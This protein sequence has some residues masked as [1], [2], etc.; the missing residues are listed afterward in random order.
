M[1][2]GVLSKEEYPY[3]KDPSGSSMHASSP[4]SR[5]PI[6]PNSRA[7]QS[8]RTTAKGPGSTWASRGR[9]SSDDGYSRFAFCSHVCDTGSCCTWNK[10]VCIRLGQAPQAELT[11]MSNHT[12]QTR[13]QLVH[14][15]AKIMHGWPMV[16]ETE[17]SLAWTH[18]YA[19][20]WLDRHSSDFSWWESRDNL[21]SHHSALW[22]CSQVGQQ[23]TV[24]VF[25]FSRISIQMYT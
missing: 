25:L 20:M 1:D 15:Q 16:R 6:A 18:T 9:A 14:S 12:N 8:R 19:I 7:V 2:K 10:I 4:F 11:N 23:V 3:L 22:S 21:L 13:G 24:T 5:P 17:E